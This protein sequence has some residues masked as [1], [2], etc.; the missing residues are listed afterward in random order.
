VLARLR[1]GVAAGYDQFALSWRV[2]RYGVRGTLAVG[3]EGKSLR[4]RDKTRELCIADLTQVRRFGE[5]IEARIEAVAS[6]YA[7]TTGYAPREGDIVVDIG[8][9]LGEFSLWCSDA[10][11]RVIAFE[12]DPAAFACLQRNLDRLHDVRVFPHAAWKE[13]ATLTL[14]GAPDSDRSSLIESG[15]SG[16]VQAEVEAWPLDAHPAIA[17]LPVIDFMKIAGE[18]VEPE[19]MA[20]ATRTLRRTRVIAVDIGATDRRPNLAARVSAI[21]EGM[22]FS[23]LAHDRTDSIFALN[24]AMVGPFNN[25]VL[26]PRGS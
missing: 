22:R 7:G 4:I 11:A 23:P 5:G 1:R 2:R 6:K 26:G 19:I 18:G 3:R 14:H 15:T 25:R 17:R 9:G 16:A 12:P 8:A 13:R 24:T 10:G 21:L 20:G